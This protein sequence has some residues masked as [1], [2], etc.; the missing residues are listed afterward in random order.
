MAQHQ[1]QGLD[2]YITQSPE[3]LV[4][5]DCQVCPVYALTVDDD[6]S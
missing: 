1:T 5:I 2:I 3:R 4:L 6:A